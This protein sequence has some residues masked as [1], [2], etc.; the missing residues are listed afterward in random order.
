MSKSFTK[1][2]DKFKLQKK[3]FKSNQNT[4]ILSGYL[5]PIIFSILLI[6]N[7]NLFEGSKI[8]S[9]FFT[10]VFLGL[11]MGT[12]FV[13]LYIDHKDVHRILLVAFVILS[14][15]WIFLHKVPDT[16]TTKITIPSMLLIELPTLI[17]YYLLSLFFTFQILQALIKFKDSL[18]HSIR[19][20]SLWVEIH[21]KSSPTIVASIIAGSSTV[22][23]AIIGAIVTVLLS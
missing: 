15:V 3:F 23:V 10:Y 1:L 22:V 4:V 20:I 8:A 7:Y 12:I 9:P 18:K 5:S 14:L 2:R 13:Y 16:N 17:D 11:I 19:K 6:C 21:P